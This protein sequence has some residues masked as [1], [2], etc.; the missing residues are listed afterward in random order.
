MTD[1]S[2]AFEAQRGI[3][4]SAAANAWKER[5][6]PNDGF[7]FPLRFWLGD[8]SSFSY[9]NDLYPSL[10]EV[11]HISADAIFPMPEIAP[12]SYEEGEQAPDEQ[13]P[14][15]ESGDEYEA[16]ALPELPPLTDFFLSIVVSY[17]MAE[18]R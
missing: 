4:Y 3:T 8:I 14:D 7:Y 11:S 2:E 13:A 5:C 16:Q 17:I 15:E 10:D 12:V 9:R 6:L 18:E 1:S